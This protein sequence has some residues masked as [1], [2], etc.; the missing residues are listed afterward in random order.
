V[1]LLVALSVSRRGRKTPPL[2]PSD[3]DADVAGGPAADAQPAADE[4][5]TAPTP[6]G[7]AVAGDE[8]PAGAPEQPTAQALDAPA[9]QTIAEPPAEPAA[10]PAVS[11]AHQPP[12]PSPAAARERGDDDHHRIKQLAARLGQAE[13]AIASLQLALAQATSRIRMLQE[14]VESQPSASPAAPA[15]PS[16]T[17][18]PASA[19]AAV[20]YVA[21]PA[22]RKRDLGADILRLDRQ[23]LTHE[24]I[25][26]QLNTTAGEVELVL[27]LL[28]RRSVA[29]E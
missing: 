2:A 3:A 16:A 6:P 17:A 4:Q 10:E 15:A 1:V 23:G 27:N 21:E 24:Q 9:A 25:A 13:S 26:R 5:P 14:R 22:R 12:S 20:G 8:P 28:K 19:A 29:R 7:P 18:P 11:T